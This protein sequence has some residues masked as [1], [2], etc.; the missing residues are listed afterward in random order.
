MRQTVHRLGDASSPAP[1]VTQTAPVA[2]TASPAS[3]GHDF[4]RVPVLQ[5]QL[6]QQARPASGAMTRD[7]FEETMSRRYGV[8][9]ITV[10]TMAAQIADLRRVTRVSASAP[11]VLPGWTSYDPGP[12]SDVY[13]AIARA[14]DDFESSIGGV[15]QVREILFF[16]VE[17]A[18]VDARRAWETRSNVG[19]KFGGGKLF[20][21][22]T[23]MSRSVG[24]PMGRSVQSGRYDEPVATLGRPPGE[25]PGA[26]IPLA[27]REESRRRVIAHELGHGLA[28]AAMQPHGVDDPPPDPSMIADFRQAVGWTAGSSPELFDIGDPTVASAL[29]A[30]TRPP[31]SAGPIT[32][33][34]WNA[35]RW[36]EQPVSR[37]SVEAGPAED[38]ADSVSAYVHVPAVLRARSPARFRF[39]DER[40]S[41]WQRRL[42]RTPPVGDFPLPRGD[43]RV[44]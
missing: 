15:P 21:F 11:D 35:P 14:F 3:A 30:G 5:R 43:T 40:R 16:D 38:F 13:S 37:Y 44:A 19:A 7:E 17:Y 24:F 33:D 8:T 39:L 9:T 18:W 2:R 25:T 28:E 32:P 23:G 26:P 27:M 29:S 34:E 41:R 31:S 10:G 22:R 4:A 1:L 42:V 6:A 20:V 36:R 12:S